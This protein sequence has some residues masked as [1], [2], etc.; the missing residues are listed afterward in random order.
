[1]AFLDKLKQRGI[2]RMEKPGGMAP[3]G[4][5]G[6]RPSLLPGPSTAQPTAQPQ[7][8]L[9][10]ITETIPS[11]QPPARALTTTPLSERLS[12]RGQ[13]GQLGSTFQGGKV[14]K[15]F[16]AD[17]PANVQLQGIQQI[18]AGQDTNSPMVNNFVRNLAAQGKTPEEIRIAF[19]AQ[20]R[21]SPDPLVIMS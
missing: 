18:L 9:P 21:Q 5:A 6:G 1:M 13:R 4:P 7:S 17:L 14:Q 2:K 12:A 3:L 15:R 20:Q 8:P 10:Q 11:A 19:I 16:L